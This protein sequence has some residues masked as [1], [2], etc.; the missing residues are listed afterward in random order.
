[1]GMNGNLL[2]TIDQTVRRLSAT[3]SSLGLRQHSTTSTSR[4][5]NTIVN[6]HT[7]KTIPIVTVTNTC[8]NNKNNTSMQSASTT[9][10][11]IAAFSELDERPVPHD[12]AET[13]FK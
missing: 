8:K 9:T 7:D 4:N 12:I 6:N 2:N 13:Y 3:G 1:M 11:A 10:S 5:S